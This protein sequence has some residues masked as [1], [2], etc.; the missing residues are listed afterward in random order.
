MFLRENIITILVLINKQDS[1]CLEY[2]TKESMLLFKALQ[3]REIIC[4]MTRNF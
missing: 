2:V 1:S 3:N 4:D